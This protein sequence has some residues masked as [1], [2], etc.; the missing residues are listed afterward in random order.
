MNTRASRLITTLA[1]LGIGLVALA[2]VPAFFQRAWVYANPGPD[3][4]V[5]SITI[6]PSAPEVSQTVYITVVTRTSA[7]P[8]ASARQSFSTRS[9]STRP[10]SRRPT[11]PST[12]TPWARA[13]RCGPA[14]QRHNT[15][16]TRLHHHRL[17]PHRLRLGRPGQKIA[18]DD[19][20][21]N[22]PSATVCVGIQ[23]VADAYEPDNTCGTSRWVTNTQGLFPQAHTLWPQG[24]DDWVK[25]SAVAGV[26]YTI[27]ATN[28]ETH[29][30]PQLYS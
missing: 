30:D 8:P 20:S 24:D 16:T 12:P 14:L 26:S 1:A 21:N 11:P 13:S 22:I 9:I 29:A 3:L 2:L 10:T 5:A 17:H 19:E 28:L 18:E 7:T 25:F 15:R 27:Q 23:G 4:V 6:S